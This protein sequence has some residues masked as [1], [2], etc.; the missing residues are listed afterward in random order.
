M[1][2]ARYYFELVG[3]INKHQPPAVVNRQNNY[4]QINNTIL[5]QENLNQLS[6]EQLKEIENI[7]TSTEIK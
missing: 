2:A 3:E 4:I 6:A 5:S 1:R 7:V